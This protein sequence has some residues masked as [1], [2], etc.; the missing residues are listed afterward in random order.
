M[1]SVSEQRPECPTF[2]PEA[3]H[4]ESRFTSCV[5]ITFSRSISPSGIEI[6]SGEVQCGAGNS[7]FIRLKVKPEVSKKVR[8]EVN[9]GV[10]LEV[11]LELRP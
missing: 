4:L 11:K 6:P 8:S 7:L 5:P 1:D 9:S 10:K 3:P 2:T